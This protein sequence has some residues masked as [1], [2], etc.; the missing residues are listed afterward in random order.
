[1][2]TFRFQ[3]RNENKNEIGKASRNEKRNYYFIALTL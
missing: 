3:Q 2:F 1:M